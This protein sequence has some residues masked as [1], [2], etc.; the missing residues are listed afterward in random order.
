MSMFLRYFQ[1]DGIF[2]KYSNVLLGNT[3]LGDYHDMT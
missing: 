1:F 3:I 2:I